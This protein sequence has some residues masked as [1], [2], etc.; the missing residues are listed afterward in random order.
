M[1]KTRPLGQGSARPA[2]T[3][4]KVSQFGVD[5]DTTAVTSASSPNAAQQL[6]FEAHRVWHSSFIKYCFPLVIYWFPTEGSREMSPAAPWVLRG[7]PSVVPAPSAGPPGI[8]P[9]GY[10]LCSAE[11]E[12]GG[13]WGVDQS[14]PTAGAA[15]VSGP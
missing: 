8:F 9:F 5:T 11:E 4:H 14:F 2:V 7:Y 13:I 3:V 15:A 10:S 6:C 1:C 12:A